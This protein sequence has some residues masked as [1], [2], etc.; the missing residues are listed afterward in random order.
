MFR[1][2]VLAS[3]MAL[4]L[5]GGDVLALE[6]GGMR[7]LSALNQ[8]FVGEIDLLDVKPD[9]LDAVK[10]GIASQEA[11]S[12]AG[13]ERY[14]Y[15]TKL[16]FSPQIS[17]QGHTVIRV[18]SRE[19]IR[20]P[21][22]DFLVEVAWPNGQLVK[23]YTVLLDPPAT[24]GRATPRIDAP[25]ASSLSASA[26]GEPAPASAESR[27]PAPAAG[28]AGSFPMQFGPVRSG[29][30]LWRIAT[31][32]TPPGATPA[33][34]AMAL[35]RNNQ[36]AFIRGDI[37]R[38]IANK[39]LVIP[40]AGELFALAPDAA[41][42]EYQAALR[43]GEVRRSPIT[44]VPPAGTG[45]GE[46]ESLLR[47]AGTAPG[48]RAPAEPASTGES[49]DMEQELLL[50]RE[51]SESTRR[52]TA[53]L[54]DRI[55]ELEAQLADIQTLLRLRN[56]ELARL[57]GDVAVAGAPSLPGG[58]EQTAAPEP[59]P[60]AD[61]AAA[62]LA[63]DA[64]RDDAPD[65]ASA[66]QPLE[67]ADTSSLSEPPAGPES[68]VEA[69][70]SGPDAPDLVA[71]AER[72]GVESEVTEPAAAE[73]LGAGEPGEDLSSEAVPEET[74]VEPFWR[75]MPLREAG[76]G[77]TAV[78]GLGLLW[79]VLRRRRARTADL[80]AKPAPEAEPAREGSKPRAVATEVPEEK[81]PAEQEKP[82]RSPASRSDEP[83]RQAEGGSSALSSFLHGGLDGDESD[84][85]S[86]ADIYI[87]YGR[88]RE[89][90]ALLREEIKHS[91][92]RLD[93]RF[94]L[95]ETYA[96]AGNRQSLAVLMREIKASGG[97]QVYPDQWRD[98]EK[99]IAEGLPAGLSGGSADGLET[100]RPRAVASA[101]GPGVITSDPGVAGLDAMDSFDL[102][103]QDSLSLEMGAP[104]PREPGP[105]LTAGLPP[106]F[107]DD[108]APISLDEDSYSRDLDLPEDSEEIGFDD[109]LTIPRGSGFVGGA[110]DLELTIDD[111]RAASDL[112]LDSFAAATGGSSRADPAPAGRDLPNPS[113]P[114]PALRALDAGPA[115]PDA[116][117]PLEGFLGADDEGA[118]SDLL[119]SQWQMD[120]GLWDEIATKLDLARAYL[121]MEDGES[122]K[123]ILEE[124]VTEGS[125]DQRGEAEELLRRLG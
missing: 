9:E 6:L 120:S 116:D 39:R 90:E 64:L 36:D 104:P 94:K 57:Q 26:S 33:Q 69:A 52:E 110:S 92:D 48:T 89:A 47:I 18:T 73:A 59:S 76:L 77:A 44:D 125:D 56:A 121:E 106:A 101:D 108:E 32:R 75:A 25:V 51:A 68:G 2:H 102:D 124:V 81:A 50:V 123:G 3:A 30:G 67:A 21:Y 88:Y 105:R 11:F 103:S 112:D 19:P 98:L 97:D 7:T 38:L 115:F 22:I 42:Q 45:G 15:L 66:G 85:I 55:R 8:P 23:E 100:S 10:A 80:A 93:V 87:A 113:A 117:A 27:G 74:G 34:T 58:L 29:T 14:Q 63:A 13:L 118:S 122:A 70:V 46:A 43:G 41:K 35:F 65:T 61:L 17:T 71:T 99:R 54:R 1:K 5:A 79:S 4:A 109:D 114:R 91:P 12:E 28:Y 16:Q 84:V 31:S 78:L 53:E 24:T 60:D 111:L 82:P 62:L 107:D 37:N 119:T 83:A 72:P 86:E 49:R 20:E 95:A 96:G 40:T